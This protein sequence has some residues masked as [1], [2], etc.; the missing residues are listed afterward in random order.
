MAYRKTERCP[1]CGSAATTSRGGC[2]ACGHAW[3]VA[4]ACPHCA[5]VCGVDRDPDLGRVCRGC[6]LPRRGDDDGEGEGPRG[7]LSTAL[8]TELRAAVEDKRRARRLTRAA[9]VIAC[10]CVPLG[11]FALE[12]FGVGGWLVCITV[13]CGALACAPSRARADRRLR[14]VKARAGGRAA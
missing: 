6:A 7:A 8:A 5:A 11:L 12:H 9:L 10:A 1:A 4:Y 2:H 3:G 14:W 13:W